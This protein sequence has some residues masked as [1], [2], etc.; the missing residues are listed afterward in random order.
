[1]G[2]ADCTSCHSPHGAESRGLLKASRHEP[3]GAGR[4]SECHADGRPPAEQGAEVCLRCHGNKAAD[5]QALSSHVGPGVF[6]VSCHSPHAS[7]QPALQKAS[8]ERLCLNCHWDT[9][10]RMEEDGDHRHPLVDKGECTSCHRPHGSNRAHLF[11]VDELVL[12][13]S[14][15]ERQATFTHPV[16]P[17]ARDP[18]SR[19]SISCITCHAPMGGPAE[20]NLRF[21]RDRELCVQ[22]HKGY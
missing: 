11:P 17:E 10:Q 1:V 2:G 14:C 21:G 9:R 20:Y 18:R 7:D 4:C 15:H 16:G 8:Q 12:C 3:F 6:C 22:C 5:F 19:R 13:T